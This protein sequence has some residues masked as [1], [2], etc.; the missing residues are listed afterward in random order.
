MQGRDRDLL[1][2]TTDRYQF[3]VLAFDSETGE[4]VTEARGD[5]RVRPLMP[6]GWI[7]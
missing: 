1:L 6:F 2:L 3:C 4:L 7:R 5:A